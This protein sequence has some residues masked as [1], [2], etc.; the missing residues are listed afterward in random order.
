MTFTVHTGRIALMLRIPAPPGQVQLQHT[1]FLCACTPMQNFVHQLVVL[2]F[3]RSAPTPSTIIYE[4]NRLFVISLRPPRRAARSTEA[5]ALPTDSATPPL[6]LGR[7][8]FRC[9]ALGNSRAPSASLPPSLPPS[10]RPSVRL[11]SFG[12][13][14]PERPTFETRGK[15]ESEGRTNFYGNRRRSQTTAAAAAVTRGV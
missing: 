4:S 9:Y 13:E 14:R 12:P 10:V 6:S 1:S 7:P 3:F 5:T 8:T 2:F 15:R 11:P